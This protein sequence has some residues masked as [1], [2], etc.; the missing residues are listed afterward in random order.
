MLK[1]VRTSYCHYTAL[2]HYSHKIHVLMIDV[3]FR[4]QH[5]IPTRA[6]TNRR[7][8]HPKRYFRGGPNGIYLIPKQP[9]SRE[10]AKNYKTVYC[11]EF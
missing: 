7:R 8:T 4:P 3:L 5:L 6:T 1:T 11:V 10:N 9:E 2:V